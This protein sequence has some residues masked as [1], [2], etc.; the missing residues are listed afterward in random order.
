MHATKSKNNFLF[1]RKIDILNEAVLFQDKLQFKEKNKKFNLK[2]YQKQNSYFLKD[3]EVQEN[4]IN[5]EDDYNLEIYN[6]S[7][8]KDQNF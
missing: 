4:S 8:S 6:N 7:I 5:E 2:I 1:P 3:K